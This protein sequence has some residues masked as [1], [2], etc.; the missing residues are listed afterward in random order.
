MKLWKDRANIL[1][2]DFVIC[3]WYLCVFY[4]VMDDVRD[5]DTSER[6]ESVERVIKGLYDGLGVKSYS[7]ENMCDNFLV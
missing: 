6:H 3:G 5:I 2:S 1:E 4:R 7:A